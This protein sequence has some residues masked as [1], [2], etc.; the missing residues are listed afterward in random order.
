MTSD[1]LKTLVVGDRVKLLKPVRRGQP[2]TQGT[3]IYV[4]VATSPNLAGCISSYVEFDVDI[5]ASNFR[6][7][8]Y[9]GGR[10]RHCVWFISDEGGFL[11]GAEETPD[12]IGFVGVRSSLPSGGT[13]RWKWRDN[14]ASRPRGNPT[15]DYDVEGVIDGTTVAVSIDDGNTTVFASAQVSLKHRTLAVLTHIGGDAEITPEVV[16]VVLY[17]LL[18]YLHLIGYHG[19]VL[20]PDLPN[21]ERLLWLLRADGAIMRFTGQTGHAV[22]LDTPTTFVTRFG[23]D[24]I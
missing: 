15:L 6:D 20:S 24:L 18:S 4:E 19:L 3:V 17:E 2:G 9:G 12:H 10:P 21:F 16:K 22:L 13:P 11:R 1:E 14:P 5:G 23:V 8:K 7:Q